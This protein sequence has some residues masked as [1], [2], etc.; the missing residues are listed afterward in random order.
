M[1]YISPKYDEQPSTME[2]SWKQ[3]LRWAKGFYQIDGKY[4]VQNIK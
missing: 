4:L 1:S 3:R 2:Q